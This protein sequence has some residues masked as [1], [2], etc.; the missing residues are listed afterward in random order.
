VYKKILVALDGSLLAEKGLE[1]AVA[2]VKQNP[3]SKLVLLT[4]IQA[5]ALGEGRTY[6]GMTTK[7]LQS[8]INQAS[9]EA[10]RKYMDKL[11]SKLKRQ[12]ID[13]QVE[14]GWGDAAEGIVNYAEKNQIDLVVITTHGRSGLG[15]FFLGSVA[16]KVISTSP[17]PVL[18]IPPDKTR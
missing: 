10:S 12:G 17:V 3:G 7:Q 4:I 16:S 18:V 5:L 9:E 13:M 2:T 11:V 1:S 8:Q 6:G 15:K 14:I